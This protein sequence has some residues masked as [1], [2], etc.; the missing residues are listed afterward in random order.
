MSD[1]MIIPPSGLFVERSRDQAR[2]AAPAGSIAA[3]TP[4]RLPD[5]PQPMSRAR[6]RNRP[7]GSAPRR[8]PAGRRPAG[9]RHPDRA[10]RRRRRN[11][12]RARRR[13]SRGRAGRASHHA[14]PSGPAISTNDLPARSMVDTGLPS[15]SSQT[16]GAREPGRPKV[17]RG[18]SCTFSS[19]SSATIGRR[20]VEIAELDVEV[21]GRRLEILGAEIGRGARDIARVGL[22]DGE[23]ADRLALGLVGLEQLR[24]RPCPA[25]P[26]RASRR[27]CARRGCRY[28]RRSR[29]SA[30]SDARH[31][32]RGTRGRP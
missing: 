12:S 19:W 5:R 7:A 4:S 25:A 28:C 20:A 32:R 21:V 23:L 11:A 13:A 15:R 9:S 16:C 6:R 3:P 10:A 27:G 14:L 22:L 26:A 1:F 30:A 31:R 17:W 29:R 8:R 24:L 18:S 2:H